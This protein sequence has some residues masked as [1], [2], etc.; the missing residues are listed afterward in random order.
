MSAL[1][2]HQPHAA[3]AIIGTSR[4]MSLLAIEIQVI[5][6]WSCQSLQKVDQYAMLQDMLGTQLCVISGGST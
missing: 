5:L 6:V 4:E 2:I 3:F 1:S